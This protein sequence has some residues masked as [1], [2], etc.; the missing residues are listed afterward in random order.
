MMK[1]YIY[2]F[3]ALL[4]SFSAFC[5][6]LSRIKFEY[7]TVD[8]GLSQGTIEDILQDRQGMMWFATRD[9]LNRY[10]GQQVKVFRN[11]SNDPNSLASNWVLSLAMDPGGKLWIGSGGLNVYDPILDRITRIPVNTG[12]DKA[13]HGGQVYDINVDYDSTLW[14]SST[15]GLVHYFPRKNIFT[16]YVA[17]PKSPSALPVNIIY[18]TLVTRDGRLFVAPEVDPIYEFNRKDGTFREIPYKHGYPGANFTKSI[19]EDQNGLFY[20]T[21]E[22]SAVHIYNP[23]TSE[24]K[25]ITTGEGGL[26]ALSIKSK[27]LFV[28]PHEIWI[29]T[30]GG[31]INIYDPLAGTMQYVMP[32]TRNSTSLNSKAVLNLYQ[33]KDQ[34]IWVGH[35]NTGISVWKRN[36]EKF[37]SYHNNPFDPQSLNKEVVCGIFED[38]NGK[39]WVAQDGGGLDLFHPESRT[40]EHFR[41]EN[42]NPQSLTTDVILTIHE[43]PDGNLLLG[44]YSGGLMIFDPVKKKVIKA[45]GRSDGLPCLNIWTI[46]KDSKSRYWIAFLQS[47]VALYN[48]ADRSFVYYTPTD[49]LHRIS[50]GMIMHITEDNSGKI[51][52]G[53]ENAGVCVLD[54][55]KG[56]TRNYMNDEKN[57]NSLS[58]N[59]VKSILFDDKYAWIATNGGGLNR[60]DLKTDSFRV[61]NM[62]SGLTSDA[63][64]AMLKDKK[65]NLWISSTRGMM[66]F[67]PVTFEIEK[68]DKSQ[69]LQGTEFKYN[70]ECLLRDGRMMFGGVDGLTVFNPDSIGNSQVLASVVFTDLK[71]FNESVIPGQ[72][73]SPLKNHI[74]FT[75]HIRLRHNQSVFTLEFAS[76]DYNSPKKNLYRY[77]LEGFDDKWVEAGNRNFVTYTNLD[78]GK[79]T[80]VLQGSNSDGVWN[81]T[82]RKIFIR[83]RPPWYR[84][85]VAMALFILILGYLIYVYIKEREI[86]AIHDKKLLQEKIDEAKSQLNNKV[87]ELEKQ[88]DEL[89]KRD[90]AEKDT[91]FLMEGVARMSEIIAKK[92]RNLEDLA[93]GFIAELVRYVDASAGDIFI[94]DDSDP[95]RVS[96]KATGEFSFSTRQERKLVISSGEGYVGTCYREMKT[97]MIDNL[98]DDYVILK[99]GLGEIS[100]HHV[101]LVPLVQDN[102]CVGVI[103]IASVSRLE[104]HKIRF[105]EKIAESLASV[106]TIIKA[107]EKSNLMLEQNNIQAEELHAQEEEMRQNLEELMATQETSQKRTRELEEELR[108]KTSEVNALQEELKILKAKKAGA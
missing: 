37:I 1:K 5:T 20:I 104:E 41:H 43:D 76:I 32:D 88:Q 2:L 36:K 56:T 65:G 21:A 77:R 7:L 64:M 72:K 103:E 33:D 39:I 14:I 19:Q 34:N 87:R 105:I 60:L 82:P 42:G 31:G 53:S 62:A 63:L 81:E 70:A 100:L 101:I 26:N 58:N 38:S 30:D 8:D 71:I 86:R 93:T 51:W 16:T 68:Y 61:F 48:P 10:D 3:Q 54:P 47:G 94:A 69:G 74:N 107:N 24:S 102:V 49:S 90:E 57:R 9:G 13:F 40:F 66:K 6:D 91:R 18:S 22:N 50:S 55:E 27:V 67:N 79:Y 23:R 80:F 85:F 99:S 97:L 96:L 95:A 12:D 44:T 15:N 73:G 83:I 25:M 89:R 46:F 78:P 92:R 4:F 29:G 98:P 84:T 17:D 28:S 108:L 45:F 35:Y 52:L 11:N 59:D 75:D 106:V